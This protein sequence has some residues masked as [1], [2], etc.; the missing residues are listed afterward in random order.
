MRRQV[1]LGTLFLD[2]FKEVVLSFIT[3]QVLYEILG[4]MNRVLAQTGINDRCL[5]VLL[6][7]LQLLRT[8]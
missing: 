1:V 2:G 7:C 6:F 5:L 3:L 8:C 4:L